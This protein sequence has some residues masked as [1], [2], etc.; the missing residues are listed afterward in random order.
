MGYK[1]ITPYSD[2]V[3][4]DKLQH[5]DYKS[6]TPYGP[7]RTTK[8]PQII[9]I[10]YTQLSSSSYATK[11]GSNDIEPFVTFLFSIKDEFILFGSKKVTAFVFIVLFCNKIVLFSLLSDWGGLRLRG[12]EVGKLSEKEGTGGRLRVSGIL[13]ICSA[14]TRIHIFSF[15]NSGC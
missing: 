13:Y 14:L 12:I 10:K 15:V 4:L 7:V 9:Q 8:V 2:D 5:M 6:I 1:T 11:P 3:C